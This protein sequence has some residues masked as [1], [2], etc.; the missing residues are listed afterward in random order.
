MEIAI[1]G[2][3]GRFPDARNVEEFC[4]NLRDGICSIKEFPEDRKR[5]LNLPWE[6]DFVRAGYMSGIEFFDYPFFDISRNEAEH[7]DP[8]Q[9]LTMEVFYETIEN[10]GYDIDHFFDSDSSVWIAETTLNYH[11]FMDEPGPDPT[12]LTGNLTSMTAGRISRFFNLRGCALTIGSSC[13]SSLVALH[14]ACNELKLGGAD[15]AFVCGSKLNLIPGFRASE[16][17]ESM[18]GITSPNEKICSFSSEANGTVAGE[19]VICFLLKPLQ[20]ALA[21]KDIIHAVI[22]GTAVNQDAALSATLVA[23]DSNAQA[24]VIEKAWKQADISPE[25]ISFIEAHGTGTKLGDPI[26]VQGLDLAFSKFTNKRKFCALSTVKT[27]IGHTDCVA[28]LAG[29][30]RAS[31]SLKSRQLFPLVNFAEPNPLIDFEKSAV[32]PTA[33]LQ[34]WVHPKESLRRAGVSSFGLAGT[35]CHV[36]LE[37]A[38]PLDSEPRPE[39]KDVSYLITVSAKDPSALESN[40]QALRRYISEYDPAIQ[41]VSYTL[42]VG[43]KH[44]KYRFVEIVRNNAE[45][46]TALGAFRKSEGELKDNRKIVFIFSAE[47]PEA[48][49][50]I[51]RMKRQSDFFCA[52]AERMS[53]IFSDYVTVQDNNLLNSFIF[54]YVFYRLLAGRYKNKSFVGDGMGQIVTQV[55]SNDLPPESAIQ[56]IIEFKRTESKN[57]RERC[58][59]MIGNLKSE[60]VLFVEVGPESY[61]S[62]Q[63]KELQKELNGYEVLNLKEGDDALMNFVKELYLNNYV[64][65]WSRIGC[66]TGGRRIELP[67]Y[68]FNKVRCWVSGQKAPNTFIVLPDDGSH[69]AKPDHSLSGRSGSSAETRTNPEWTDTQNRVSGLWYEVLK[70]DRIDLADDFFECGG[71]SLNGNQLVNKITKEFHV[72]FTLEELFEFG[73]LRDLAIRIDEKLVNRDDRECDEIR[74]VPLKEYFDV[75][76][77]QRRMWILCQMGKDSAKSY[78]LSCNLIL[79]RE[80]DLPAFYQAVGFILTRHE[81]LRTVFIAV[82]NLPKQ[83]LLPG[84][85]PD[86]V[87]EYLDVRGQTNIKELVEASIEEQMNYEFNLAAGPLLR[88]KLLQLSSQSIVVLFS[89]HHIVFDALSEKVLID[90]LLHSYDRFVKGELPDLKPLEFQYKDF[91]AWQNKKLQGEG[92][93]KAKHFWL[94]MY[95]SGIPVLQL[96]G[97]FNRPPVKTFKG[98]KVDFSIGPANYSKLAAFSDENGATLFVVLLSLVSALLHRYSDQGDFVI[99]TPVSGRQH[100]NLENQIGLFVNTLPLRIQISESDKFIDLV[101]KVKKISIEAIDN[102]IFPFD[103]LVNELNLQRDVSRHPLFDVMMSFYHESGFHGNAEENEGILS[104]G[105]MTTKFDLTFNFHDAGDHIAFIIEYNTDIFQPGRIRK[106][107]KD[108]KLLIAELVNKAVDV[109]VHRVFLTDEE[110]QQVLVGFNDTKREY[111]GRDKTVVELFEEQVRRRPEAVAVVFEGREL[112]YGELNERSNRLGWYLRRQYGVVQ[113]DLV[114]IMAERSEWMI[115]GILGILKSGAGYVPVDKG[116]P[117]ALKAFMVKDS[118]MKYLLCEGSEEAAGV[119]VNAVLFRS[120]WEELIA[121]ECPDNPDHISGSEDIVYAMYT[122]G[123]TGRPKGCVIEHRNVT[124]L[125][126]GV[127][128]VQLGPEN[129][130]LST[131]SPS[132]DATTFEYWGMLLNGGRLV[133]CREEKLLDAD[134]LKRELWAREVNMIWLTTSLF[135]QLVDTDISLFSKLHTVL[136]GGEKI[137]ERHI[138]KLKGAYGAIGIINCYGP[139]ENTTFSMT[140]DIDEGQVLDRTIPVGYPLSNRQVYILDEGLQL[141]PIGVAGEICLGGAGLARGYLNRAELMAERFVAYP[142]LPYKRL[143]RTGDR[144]RWRPDGA[145]EFLGRRDDQVKLRGYRIELGEISAVLNSYP[146]VKT[147]VALLRGGVNG[148]QIVAYYEAES[149]MVEEGKIRSYLEGRLPGYMVPSYLVKVEAFPLTGNGKIDQGRL[150][151]PVELGM[152][153][154]DTYV[155]PRNELE[156]QLVEIWEEVLGREHVGIR[157]SFFELGGDS[158]KAIAVSVLMKRIDYRIEMMEVFRHFTIEKLADQLKKP[159]QQKYPTFLLSSNKSADPFSLVQNIWSE[160][161]HIEYIDPDADFFDIGGKNIISILDVYEAYQSANLPIQ[162]KDIFNYSTI[163]TMARHI[164]EA[165]DEFSGSIIK[166]G[167]V[168]RIKPPIILIPTANGLP[169]GFNALADIL[170]NDFDCYS[171]LLDNTGEKGYAELSL[172][173]LTEI[174]SRQINSMRP[175]GKICLLGYSWGVSFAFELAKE[176]ELRQRD[177]KLVLVDMSIDHKLFESMTAWSLEEYDQMF[178]MQ[179]ELLPLKYRKVLKRIFSANNAIFDGYKTTGLLKADIAG[180]EATHNKEKANMTIWA[181][182]TTGKLSIGYLKGDHWDALSTDNLSVIAEHI[183][184]DV[185]HNVENGIL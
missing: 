125:V 149:D 81:S 80:L 103:S 163:R 114:G 142:D 139:T 33:R 84:F 173:Q 43:R 157:D 105:G 156:R 180:L 168:T 117:E 100:A 147:S 91:S 39:T 174:Y 178:E 171:V 38:P 40:V 141:C 13:S 137:S 21:D 4:K 55:L 176:L 22:K 3:S 115:V 152:G 17:I 150:P 169:L 102:Q 183:R 184:S 47:I 34:D 177:V 83:M 135:N 14:Y 119:G 106:M 179:F 52:E 93:A 126:Q 86:Q 182:F 25:S 161:L 67:A 10:A 96:P 140:Y 166:L 111:A 110:R 53:N 118:G 41:D 27:N 42:A 36:V 78:N 99:G 72:E 19:A 145:V 51:A 159:Q 26:E 49:Q 107:G 138:K 77:S 35:N 94:E 8:N 89:V 82:D 29:L 121:S 23:P 136:T 151:D 50:L 16:N 18:T 30:V 154:A 68:Q 15:Y 97:D 54:Q 76:H 155:A 12:I 170:R 56:K 44:Y 88:F 73:N 58:L 74:P 175:Y 69:G 66:M 128:Y 24:Q 130:L 123:S 144:G 185:Y 122:S 28:G 120:W 6:A 59:K 165:D 124:S 48:D 95:K 75:S 164:E 61:I 158:I 127:T 90:E 57:I 64:V 101:N 37:E 153:Q 5:L 71:H 9:R 167:P 104:T 108:F 63:M 85:S 11:R 2:M 65:D 172:Q 1:I 181:R 129:V 113:G 160:T 32:V 116:Y 70:P 112:T 133:L 131:G 7:M 98:G 62:R 46:V 132:F 87:V 148:G 143:Y 146:G 60:S 162:M 109:P 31:L 20:R 45:L 79:E 92:A 134:F